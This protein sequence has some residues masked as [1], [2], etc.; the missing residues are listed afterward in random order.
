MCGIAGVLGRGA[1]KQEEAVRKMMDSMV[2]RGPD[3]QGLYVSPSGNC[4]LGHRRLAILDLTDAASQPMVSVNKQWAFVYNGECYN[5]KEL[6]AELG[7]I[8][9]N[10]VSTGDTEVVFHYLVRNGPSILAR[11]NA[12][13]ALALWD[14]REQ[15]LLLARDRYGQ[16]PLYFTHVGE[17]V[18]FASEVR[19]LLASGLV[20]HRADHNAIL[21]YLAYGAVQEPSTIVAGVL[22]VKPGTYITFS[23]KDRHTINSYWTYPTHKNNTSP[24]ELKESFVSAVER[25]LISDVPIGLFLSGGIDSSAVTLAAAQSSKTKIKTLSV[26]FPDHPD[27]SEAKYADQIAKKANTEHHEVSVTGSDLLEM[28]PR[29]LDSMDQPTGDA[30]NTYIVSYAAKQIG[31]TVALSG[32]GGDELFAGYPTFSDI[33]KALFLRHI[34]GPIKKPAA[35]LLENCWPY[36]TKP[37]KIAEMLDCPSDVLSQYL[38]RRRVFSHRQ[39]R[40]M[41]PELANS[42]WQSG[43]ADEFSTDLAS[44]IKD[45]KIHDAIGI[46]EMRTYMVQMLLRDCDSMGMANSIEIRIPFLDTEFSTHAL[47]LDSAVRVPHNCPKWYFVKAMGDWL[48]QQIIYRPKQGFT[49][50]FADWMLSELREEILEGIAPL[51]SSCQF[52]QKDV[53]QKWWDSFCSKPKETGWFRLWALFVLGRYLKSQRLCV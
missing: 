41:S 10:I 52:M 2:H 21:S 32:L 26:V 3:G 30:I 8:G 44:Q 42:S 29:A 24:E 47:T 20:E 12:M 7:A 31:L 9:E 23:P 4:V 33:P 40:K 19:A 34:F 50:P 53:V 22:T 35:F 18:V 16:K 28:L 1:T 14:E 13:F 6:R 37:S 27:C 45:R 46:L 51:L 11:I 38:M 5:Y 15:T 43:L 48:P 36:S 39:I 17:L 49:L 25:H